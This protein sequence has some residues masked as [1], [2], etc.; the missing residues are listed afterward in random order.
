MLARSIVPTR[1]ERE[2]SNQ[3]KTG[4]AGGMIARSLSIPL[5]ID[6]VRNT[7]R[8]AG[9]SYMGRKSERCRVRVFFCRARPGDRSIG[10][11]LSLS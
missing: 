1:G 2:E 3:S 9:A 5:R 10:R 11:A 8:G 6:R 4:A 7:M